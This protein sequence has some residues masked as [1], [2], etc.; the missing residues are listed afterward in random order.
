MKS[1]KHFKMQ[2]EITHIRRRNIQGKKTRSNA[3]IKPIKMPLSKYEYATMGESMEKKKN[4][5]NFG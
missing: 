5:E 3:I 1:S 4:K 2:N